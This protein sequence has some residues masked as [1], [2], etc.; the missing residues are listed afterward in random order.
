MDG[1]KAGFQGYPYLLSELLKAHNST[2]KYQIINLAS[3]NFTLYQ[4]NTGRNYKDLCEYRQL[5]SSEPDIVISMLGAKESMN[6]ANFTPDGFVQSYNEFVK[7]M[8]NL[9]SKP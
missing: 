3:D 6:Q 4:G 1:S 2:Q 9:S 8:T 7:D 5:M